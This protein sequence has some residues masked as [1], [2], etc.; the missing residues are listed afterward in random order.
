MLVGKEAAVWASAVVRVIWWQAV[1]ALS[2]CLAL[3]VAY[4]C[5][6]GYPEGD[7]QFVGGNREP[8]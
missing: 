8:R 4:G 1:H 2:V 7:M 5:R 6:E 3:T